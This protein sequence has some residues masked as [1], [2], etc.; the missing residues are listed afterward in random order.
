MSGEVVKRQVYHVDNVDE[1]R[2]IVVDRTCK[3][4]CQA[5]QSQRPRLSNL[6][7]EIQR[8]ILGYVRMHSSS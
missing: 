2:G 6:P 4:L 3:K 5:R 7:I 1:T 8:E